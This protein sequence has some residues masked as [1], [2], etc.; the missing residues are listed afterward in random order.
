[1]PTLGQ[2]YTNKDTRGGIAVNKTFLVPL[3]SLTIQPGLNIRDIDQEHVEEFAQAWI[4]G[5]YIPAITVQIIKDKIIVIDGHHRY[6]GAKLAIER[7]HEIARVECKDFTGSEA[8]KIAFMITSSQ[9][10]QLSPVER[11]SAYQRLKNQGWTIEEIAEKVKRSVSDV[12]SH[13]CLMACEPD[14]IEMVKRNKI[15][16]ANAVQLQREHGDKSVAIANG[17]LEKAKESGK[18]KIT[19][20]FTE[21]KVSSKNVRR[22]ADIILSAQ[23]TD[24][25]KI[26]VSD[27]EAEELRQ[28]ISQ[29]NGENK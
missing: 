20:Q 26:I 17:A 3:D 10:K 13:L 7:G 5:E 28:I 22:I 25:N 23:I 16:Y 27:L 14:L 19:K 1:M 6:F 21:N 15:S 18:S 24:D 29:H 4:A 11:A 9:G 8:D 12:Q 2:L